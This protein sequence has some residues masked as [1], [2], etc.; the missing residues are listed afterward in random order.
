MFINSIC[1]FFSESELTFTFAI[2]YR[3]S[4]CLSSVCSVR[5]PYS[6]DWNFPQF[7]YAIWPSV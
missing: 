5:A 3:P 1:L 7:F 4:V 2:Y 6:G